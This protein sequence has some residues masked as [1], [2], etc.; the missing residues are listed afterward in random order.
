M[1]QLPQL[2][3]SAPVPVAPDHQGTSTTSA[4][5]RERCSGAAKSAPQEA[6]TMAPKGPKMGALAL[7]P[8]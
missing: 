8:C 2:A 1:D 6:A 5:C 7:K 4:T 3:P